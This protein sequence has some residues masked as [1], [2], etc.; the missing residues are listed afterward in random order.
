MLRFGFR[1]IRFA[2]FGDDTMKIKDEIA[3]D[4]EKE[5][6]YEGKSK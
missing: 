1:W 2:I 3:E 6:R 5:L 4:K